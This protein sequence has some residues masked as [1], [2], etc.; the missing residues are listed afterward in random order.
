MDNNSLPLTGPV[1]HLRHGFSSLAANAKSSHPVQASLKNAENIPRH[2]E[3]VSRTY[4][5][6]MA[7]RLATERELYSKAHRLPGLSSSLLG[8]SI[9]TGSDSSLTYKDYLGGKYKKYRVYQPVH[10]ST[11]YCRRSC[12]ESRRAS[13]RYSSP[14]GDQAGHFLNNNKTPILQL[15]TSAESKK[16]FR[17]L[18]VMYC[19]I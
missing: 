2:L 13:I 15:T 17:R 6:H 18:K 9:L 8:L 16:A 10:D 5:S 4:G 3:S 7:M 14:N 11:H 12:G 1:D 19:M